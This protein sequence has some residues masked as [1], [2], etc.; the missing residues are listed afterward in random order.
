MNKAKLFLFLLLLFMLVG[1][2]N[3]K[4]EPY[5]DKI[6]FLDKDINIKL[7]T[8]SEERA[9]EIFKN[10]KKIY[11]E[12]EETIEEGKRI[13]KSEVSNKKISSKLAKLIKTGVE[14]YDKSDGLI[15]IN[16]GNLINLWNDAKENN[17]IPSMDQIQNV[18]INISDIKLKD[19]Y[20]S[21]NINFSFD[22]F[23]HGQADKEVKE[24][25]TKENIKNYFINSNDHILVG[26]NYEEDNYN[27]ALVN[28]FDENRINMIST[29]N[30]YI[31]TKS[32]YYNSYKYND[33]LYSSIINPKTGYLSNNMVSVTVISDDPLKGDI[34]A[35]ILFMV[36]YEDGLKIAT[37]N[38]IEAVWYYYDTNGDEIVKETKDF[39]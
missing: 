34:L 3:K 21:G 5:E 14:W 32:I 6:S 24:Y 17:S 18:D 19:D 4:L 16:K 29:N 23:I 15:N 35:T 31:T 33:I 39:R 27:L 9:Q 22:D 11:G 38:D 7:Y 12:Y 13:S 28:P 25:L 20:L 8:N 26:L 1:C 36:D 10:L 2:S 30:K 37:E